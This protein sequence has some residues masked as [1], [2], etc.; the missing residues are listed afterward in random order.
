MPTPLIARCYCP[1]IH[2]TDVRDHLTRWEGVCGAPVP[3]RSSSAGVSTSF[4]CRGAFGGRYRMSGRRSA[5]H[6]LT[7]VEERLT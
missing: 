4:P 5:C 3:P 7:F 2:Q 1:S 6:R